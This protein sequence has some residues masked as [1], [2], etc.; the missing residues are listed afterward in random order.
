MWDETVGY[1]SKA[2]LLSEPSHASVSC[3]YS[4]MCFGVGFFSETHI[5]G[6]QA[7]PFPQA[8]EPI[9]QMP[10][11]TPPGQLRSL[12]HSEDSELRP[13]PGPASLSTT[14]H[15]ITTC[16]VSSP[17]IPGIILE[18]FFPFYFFDAQ[19]AVCSVFKRHRESNHLS[20]P[21]TQSYFSWRAA[22]TYCIYSHHATFL[23]SMSPWSSKN[24]NQ[25][26]FL[27]R[28]KLPNETFFQRFSRHGA[29]G[30]SL[31]LHLCLF[32]FMFLLFLKTSLISQGSSGARL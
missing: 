8:L 14:D 13:T 31:L 12:S 17:R 26:M 3:T 20:L 32:P 27:L 4:T 10:H 9:L 30:P 23:S 29:L 21:P 2:S 22:G 19:P 7:W 15:G 24:I 6:S 1:V 5:S 11:S 25:T 18:V 28:S 16:V